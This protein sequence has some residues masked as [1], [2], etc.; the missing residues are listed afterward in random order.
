MLRQTP[1]ASFYHTF[2]WL[3]TY[4]QHFGRDQRLRVLVV[5]AAGSPIGILPLCVRTEQYR[6]GKTRVLTY[7]LADWGTWYGP[8]GP[9]PSATMFMAMQ[10][11]RDTPRDWDL[12]ELRWTNASRS[13][14]GATDRAMRTA[15]FRPQKSSYQEVSVIRMDGD[16][17]SYIA[18]KNGKW[19]HEH[20][21]QSRVIEQLGRIDFIRYRPAGAAYG[22]GDP[23]W[24][25]FDACMDVS[26]R[27]WQAGSTNGTTLCHAQIRDY[28]RDTH[29]AAARL[30]MLDLTL[31]TVDGQPAA[32]T[33]NYCFDGRLYALR[34]GYD[35]TISGRGLGKELLARSLQDCFERGD[36]I[37]D[38]GVGDYR[39]KREFRTGVETSYQFSHFPA[40]ALRSQGVRLTRWLKARRDIKQTDDAAQKRHSA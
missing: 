31:L 22:D 4:W 14:R 27:S 36:S 21:R 3:N 8:M 10:H 30:G 9:N 15:G 20:R 28:I 19:Q 39:Y 16:W 13:D 26:Q 17:D 1:Q 38:L 6:V 25:L 40:T 18:S 11:L 29:A 37:F 34:M 32:F 24:D 2:D 12:M 23:R 33:Y 35:A 5:R 7:P